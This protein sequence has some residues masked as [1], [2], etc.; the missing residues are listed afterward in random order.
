MNFKEFERY[1]ISCQVSGKYPSW[2]GLTEYLKK[3]K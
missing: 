1:I 3:V 2:E